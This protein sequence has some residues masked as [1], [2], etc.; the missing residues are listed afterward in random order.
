MNLSVYTK[1]WMK[2]LIIRLFEKNLSVGGLSKQSQIDRVV[3]L[4]NFDFKW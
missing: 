2:F 1:L 3:D 4:A